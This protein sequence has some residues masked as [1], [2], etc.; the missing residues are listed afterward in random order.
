MI[1]VFLIVCCI[2]NPCCVQVLGEFDVDTTQ[3]LNL[4]SHT[5]HSKLFSASNDGGEAQVQ[6]STDPEFDKLY[7][8][9]K[10]FLRES[11]AVDLADVYL[12]IQSA[13]DVNQELN[14]Q[15]A[16]M[17]FLI[18]NPQFRCTLEV[19]PLRYRASLG[20]D[21]TDFMQCRNG[22]LMG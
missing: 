4:H 10:S 11:N 6:T 13:C 12:A 16:S 5:V 8:S 15:V 14:E 22:K 17:N 7:L 9:Y 18:I 19:S 1:E 2:L 20:A 21:L 3:V